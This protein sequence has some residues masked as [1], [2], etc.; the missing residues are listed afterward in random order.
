MKI[1]RTEV[2]LELH[3]SEFDVWVTPSIVEIK[4]TKKFK[5]EME[6]IL[7]ALDIISKEESISKSNIAEEVTRH[8]FNY[9]DGMVSPTTGHA[10]VDNQLLQNSVTRALEASAS[11]IFLVTGKSDNNHKCQLPIFL[12]NELGWHS[13]PKAKMSRGAPT[14]DNE[15]IPRTLDSK[16]ITS[17]VS[18]LYIISSIARATNAG[19]AKSLRDAAFSIFYNFLASLVNDTE[20]SSQLR[21][22]I[23]YFIQCR[24]EGRD[25]SVLLTPLALFQ[26]RGSV[27]ATGGHE[28]EEILRNKMSEWGLRA[29]I[30]FNTTD[31]IVDEKLHTIPAESA[32]DLV[33]EVD[34]DSVDETLTPAKTRAYDFVIPYRNPSWHPQIFIQS[35]F[36]AGDSG[37][38]SHKNVDQTS[39]TRRATKKFYANWN[40]AP[41]PLFI[42]YLDGAGYCASLNGDLKRLLALNDT[43][44]F[45]QIR[46]APIR[47]RRVIQEIGFLTPLEICHAIIRTDGN[48]SELDKALRSDNYQEK[49]IHRGIEHALQVDAIKQSGERFIITEQF[50]G[51][52]AKY[53][54]L[55]QIAENGTNFVS[56]AKCSGSILV[57]GFGP[58]YGVE[59]GKF[60]TE[61]PV[62]SDG[63]ITIATAHLIT[64]LAKS[65][66]VILR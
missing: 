1:K 18:S 32:S 23:R 13:I 14:L 50:F 31:V 39:T 19:I 20:S 28:P 24:K 3:L 56:A 27:S 10:I 7:A 55:D 46:S 58:Y 57:P 25:P 35:Q 29:K 64:E 34:S 36:Y 40:G 37:S 52:A 66:E 6:K 41:I 26:V 54:V 44:D 51:V 12:R 15:K 22:F 43:H 4:S 16:N 62:V 11:L 59:L 65:N 49:E 33:K 30:D 48:Y 21:E 42:E 5:D 9:F 63:V 53:Y 2:S 17:R 60:L 45:F 8:L 38:V 47:L 61:F